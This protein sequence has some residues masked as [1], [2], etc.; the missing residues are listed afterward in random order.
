[1]HFSV[2][3]QLSLT[4]LN[5]ALLPLFP[6]QVPFSKIYPGANSH[7]LDLMEKMLQFNPAK[8]I[9]V[10][11]ALKHPYLKK[12]HGEV[13]SCPNQVCVSLWLRLSSKHELRIAGGL[14]V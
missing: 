2:F 9:S 4:T 1:M 5:N 7:A 12:Y 3:Q 6:T 13:P 11:E 10:A 14:L 8:R